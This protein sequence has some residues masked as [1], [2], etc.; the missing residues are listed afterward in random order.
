MVAETSQFFVEQHVALIPQLVKK[1]ELE[2]F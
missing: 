1:K 2:T